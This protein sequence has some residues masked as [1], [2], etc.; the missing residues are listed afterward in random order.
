MSLNKLL[1]QLERAEKRQR[2]R[3][4]KRRTKKR[5][6][7][8]RRTKKRRTKKRTTKKRATKK[9]TTKK[10]ATKKRV[11]WR[12]TSPAKMTTAQRKAWA[13]SMKRARARKAKR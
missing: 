1:E 11:Q 12:G 10:R 9:R 5:R 6:T 4:K 3:S 2:P 8:K 7:K 13:A